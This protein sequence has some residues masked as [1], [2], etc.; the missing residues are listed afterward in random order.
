M[1]AMRVLRTAL[2]GH[3]SAI[4]IDALLQRQVGM[5]DGEVASISEH[6]RERV[7]LGLEEAATLFSATPRTELR[8]VIRTGLGLPLAAELGAPAERKV[9]TTLI[10]NE[11]DVNVSRNAA[12]KFALELGFSASA[13]VKVA[14]AVSE[15]ARNIILYAGEGTIQLE[16]LGEGVEPRLRVLATDRG[17]GI[18]AAQL[19]SILGGQY[20]SRS[21]LGKGIVGVKRVASTFN[22][23]TKPGVGTSIVAEFRGRA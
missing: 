13:A 10:R 7:A 18:P 2:R 9:A 5:H 15:L 16:P 14:T 11:V 1:N 12:R 8:R 3:L 21:G 4:S 17:P 19:A 20:R 6:E 23:E 22:I